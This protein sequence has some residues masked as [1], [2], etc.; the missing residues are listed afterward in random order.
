MLNAFK[1]TVLTNIFGPTKDG[2][3][4]RIRYTTEL[5][6]HFKE[7]EIRVIVKTA[8]LGWAEQV[9]KMEDGEMPK[10]CYTNLKVK[11]N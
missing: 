6:Y 8:R 7:P 3:F 1:R 9:M 10:K 11:G 5:Y 2:Q 4:W